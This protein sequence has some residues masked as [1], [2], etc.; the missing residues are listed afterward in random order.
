MSLN[1]KNTRIALDRYF[2]GKMNTAEMHDLEKQA[3]S[4]PFL[5][6]A[7]EGYENT[8]GALSYFNRNIL[9]KHKLQYHWL[10]ISILAIGFIIM[11]TLYFTKS[12]PIQQQSTFNV[13]K[14]EKE[15]EMGQPE[16][17]LEMLPIDIENLAEIHPNQQIK[18]KEL[19]KQFKDNTTYIKRDKS[20]LGDEKIDIKIDPDLVQEP[21]PKVVAK[22][23]FKQK[24]YPYIFF[25]HLAV[26]DY[27]TYENRE[28]IVQKTTY[29]L[30]GISAAFES[31]AAKNKPELIAET[32]GVPYLDYLEET[33]YYFSKNKY[34][35]ALKRLNIITEQYKFDLNAMF[36]GGLCYFNLGDYEKALDEFNAVLALNT[37]PFKEEAQWY[38]AKTLLRLNKMQSAE[39]VLLDI[40]AENGFY[41]DQALEQ[42]KK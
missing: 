1:H 35:Y 4:D 26:L 22:K 6:D 10:V 38:K 31:E 12:S 18:S 19:E 3:L 28:K 25:Y 16:N 21:Q 11:T 5:K 24:V 20:R 41:T 34:K 27:S 9:Y 42:L 23:L 14:I 29:K 7:M 17:Q 30:S 39:K 15:V 13:P 40:V 33:M 32:K 37:G 36:Y 2:G 8:P